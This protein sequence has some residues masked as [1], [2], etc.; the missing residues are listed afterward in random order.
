MGEEAQPSQAVVHRHHD[1]PLA[2][3]R[4]AVEKR[5]GAGAKIEGAAVEPDHHR[6]PSHRVEAAGP[7]V[8]VQ[9]ILVFPFGWE[10]ANRASGSAGLRTASTELARRALAAPGGGRLWRLPA[11]AADWRRRIRDAPEDSYR[12]VWRQSAGQ[13][14]L[15]YVGDGGV[16]HGFP[17]PEKLI[18]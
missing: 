5:H 2:R 4:R 7:D 11:Q 13:L 10:E 15:P 17:L 18:D 14:A 1:R 3:Q 12:P 16:L 9:A 6:A 8:Q